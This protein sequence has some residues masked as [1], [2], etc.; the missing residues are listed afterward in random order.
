[1]PCCLGGS[2]RLPEATAVETWRSQCKSLWSC[3]LLDVTCRKDPRSLNSFVLFCRYFRYGAP[4]VINP[5]GNSFAPNTSVPFSFNQTMTFRNSMQSN[6]YLNISN[7][8]PGAWF[9]AAHLPKASEN[10]E[11]QV[12]SLDRVNSAVY[13]VLQFLTISRSITRTK[14]PELYTDTFYLHLYTGILL[15]NREAQDEQYY[16][17]LPYRVVLSVRIVMNRL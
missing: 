15:M 17:S 16:Y 11:I 10:I 12:S 3:R 8:T 9:V 1:M 7:P 6:L 14:Q 4:P 5:L 13:I 2:F